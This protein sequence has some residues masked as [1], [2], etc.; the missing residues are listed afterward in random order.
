MTQTARTFA[1]APGS[2]VSVGLIYCYGVLAT[3]SLTKIIPVL[4]D[5]ASNL[6]APRGQFALLMSMLPIRPAALAA[7]AGSRVDRLGAHRA[8]QVVAVVG[9]AIKAVHLL[10]S[11]LQSFM[12]VRFA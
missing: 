12:A 10:S 6:V 2:W 11:S 7:V 1:P 3:A 8:V 9:V 5:L 4:G